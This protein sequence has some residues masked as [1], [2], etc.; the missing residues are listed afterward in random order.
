[1]RTTSSKFA[2]QTLKQL[3]HL[4]THHIILHIT[5]DTQK[6]THSDVERGESHSYTDGWRETTFTAP[7]TLFTYA[8][9][10]H[11]AQKSCAH[12]LGC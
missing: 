10:L 3:R 7:K 5:K 2:G 12:I 4:R 9:S 6:K 11:F 8:V 1:M